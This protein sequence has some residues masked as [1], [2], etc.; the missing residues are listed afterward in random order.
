MHVVAGAWPQVVQRLQQLEGREIKDVVKGVAG[1]PDHVPYDAAR[2]GPHAATLDPGR[3][4]QEDADVFF[5]SKVPFSLWLASKGLGF[6]ASVA[7]R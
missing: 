6:G 1:A 5:G 4:Y 7:V 3:T 2:Q